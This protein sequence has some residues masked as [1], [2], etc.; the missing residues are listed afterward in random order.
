MNDLEYLAI[1]LI[2][3][4][5]IIC[6]II[7]LVYL[8]YYIDF[9]NTN[10]FAFII[11][12]IFFFLFIFLHVVISFDF[13]YCYLVKVYNK[14]KLIVKIISEFYSYFNRVESLMNLI[15]IPFMINCLESGYY[16]T[17]RIILD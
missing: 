13:I 6:I 5:F 14:D 17:I 3:I 15:I 9:N 12:F 1:L 8:C 2:C 7:T 4:Y 16:S 11:S 10:K